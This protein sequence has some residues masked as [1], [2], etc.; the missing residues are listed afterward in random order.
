MVFRFELSNGLWGDGAQRTYH[1]TAPVNTLYGLHESLVMM[2]EEGL[3]NSWTRHQKNHELLK[4][5]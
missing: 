1:H 4:E 3:E 5:G 2:L